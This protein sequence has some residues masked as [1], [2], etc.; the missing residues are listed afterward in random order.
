MEKIKEALLKARN[1][2]AEPNVVQQRAVKTK[3]VD[4]NAQSE[5]AVLDSIE[6]INT[7]TVKLDE[8]HLEKNRIVALNRHDISATA[9]NSLRT[10][11]LQKMYE[12]NWRSIAVVSPTPACGK[13]FVAINLAISIANQPNKTAM[14]VDFDLRRPRIAKYLG[15]EV[16]KSLNNFFDGSASLDEVMINPSLPRLVVLPTISPVA[17]SAEALSS[18][19]VNGL[20]QDIY[21]R[22]ESR[23][24]VYDLPPILNAD[25]A[26]IMMRKVDCILFVV[27]SGLVKEAEVEEAMHHIPKE[28]LLGV[29]LNKAETVSEGYYY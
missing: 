26:L 19:K 25:D 12:N 15:L 7:K 20:I 9:L 10:Q 24:V 4:L 29:V 6:Y 14:L 17:N 21:E 13:T 3:V 16:E 1:K 18:A 27:G 8:A 22:Y 28:K 11:V 2:N 23:I 5:D